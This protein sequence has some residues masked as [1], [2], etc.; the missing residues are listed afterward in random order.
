MMAVLPLVIFYFQIGFKSINAEYEVLFRAVLLTYFS[1]EIGLIAANILQ[2]IWFGFLHYQAGFPIGLAGLFLTFLFGVMMGW[3]VQR[4][5][6]ILIPV[7]IHFM[8]DFV[9]FLLIVFRME[10]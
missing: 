2:A 7:V 6:G 1:R 3:L 4:T 8:A 9:V 10:E 5:K